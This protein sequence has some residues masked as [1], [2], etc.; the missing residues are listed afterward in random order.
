MRCQAELVEVGLTVHLAW[1]DR[2]TT[3]Q[4]D[5]T[6]PVLNHASPHVKPN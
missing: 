2:H 3:Q 4:L 5:V 1:I 6:N